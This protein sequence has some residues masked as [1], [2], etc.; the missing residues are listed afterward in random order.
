MIIITII[1]IMIDIND[2]FYHH[3]FQ[4]TILSSYAFTY[5]LSLL[6]LNL[7]YCHIV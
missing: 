3:Q 5:R 4:I 6:D 1:K 7:F 2:K